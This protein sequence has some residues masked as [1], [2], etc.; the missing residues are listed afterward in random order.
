MVEQLSPRRLRS[1]QVGWPVIELQRLVTLQVSPAQSL[2]APAPTGTIG[3]TT[4]NME[5]VSI[6]LRPAAVGLPALPP[7]TAPAPRA[8]TLRPGQRVITPIP[9]LPRLAVLHL[10]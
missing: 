10:Q 6:L 7:P 3:P 8:I 4:A 1:T 9:W 5:L 2:S